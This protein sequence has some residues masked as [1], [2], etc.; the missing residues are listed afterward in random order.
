MRTDYH[1][2]FE[3]TAFSPLSPR[4]RAR[5]REPDSKA[6]TPTLSRRARGEFETA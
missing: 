1:T 5:V 3:S 4:E 6:L 2:D